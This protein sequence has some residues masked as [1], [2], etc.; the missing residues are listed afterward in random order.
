[1]TQVQD[2]LNSNKPSFSLEA[3]FLQQVSDYQLTKGQ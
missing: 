3:D 1:M 2:L